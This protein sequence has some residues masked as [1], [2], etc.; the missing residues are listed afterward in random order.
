MLELTVN[1]KGKKVGDLETALEET[2]RK[3]RDGNTEGQDRNESGHYFFSVKGE[4]EGDFPVDSRVRVKKEIVDNGGDEVLILE[5]GTQG[6]VL[7]FQ[8]GHYDLR[9][10]TSPDSAWHLDEAEAEE[11][12]ELVTD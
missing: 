8:D 3:V 12:L 10:E 2:L 6:T 1:I 9:F 5:A 7:L 4:E 11:S